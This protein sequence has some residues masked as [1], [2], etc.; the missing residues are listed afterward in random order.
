MHPIPVAHI[1]SDID[2]NID[3]LICAGRGI[4]GAYWANYLGATHVH[5]WPAASRG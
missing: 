3:V 5:A 2:G 1:G 4:K